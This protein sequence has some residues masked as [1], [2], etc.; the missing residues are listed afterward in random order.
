MS[1]RETAREPRHAAARESPESTGGGGGRLED[2]PEH[3]K[4]EILLLRELETG[5]AIECYP[6]AF[7]EVDGQR[8]VIA[9]PCDWS[10]SIGRPNKEGGL[11]PVAVDSKLMDRIFPL[12]QSYLEE[13]EIHLFRTP[14]TLTLQGEFLED[15]DDDDDDD[16]GDGVD[17]DGGEN[18]Y[19][20]DE[21]IEGVDY[22]VLQEAPADFSVEDDGAFGRGGS[23]NSDDDGAEEEE[24]L[25]ATQVMEEGVELVAS[26]WDE[27]VEYS[28]VRHLEPVLLVAR[29]ATSGAYHLLSEEEALKV[30]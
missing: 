11:E 24:E 8:Y 17:G 16:G 25:E 21:L 4:R 14:V 10:V 1:R 3:L 18:D 23:G 20:E 27:G 2:V 5:R 9:E 22:E 30:R 7:A 19:F 26:F 12:L 28:L 15:G 13:D 6:D 29:A